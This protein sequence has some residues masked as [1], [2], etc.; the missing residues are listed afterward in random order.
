[1]G[2]SAKRLADVRHYALAAVAA[3]A[4]TF[5]RLRLDP[6]M[7]HSHNRHLFFLPTVMIVAWLWG[8]GPGLLA[9][10]MFAVA[11]RIF[12]TDATESFIH[13]NS[14]IALFVLVSVAICF[15]IRSL[16]RARQRADEVT[17]SREQLLAVVAHDLTNPLNAVKLAEERLRR[18]GP[19]GASVERGLDTIRNASNRMDRLLR[20]LVDTT[21]IDHDEL[22]VM[23]RP[24]PVAPLVREVAELYA[25]QAQAA[26]VTVETNLPAADA[27]VDGDRDRLM[28]V[29]GNLLANALKFT[30][31]GGRVALRA[32]ER[33]ETVVFEIEDTGAGIKPEHLPHIFERF[34]TYDTRGTGLGLFIAQSLVAAHGGALRVRSEPGKGATFWFEIPRRGR[35]AVSPSPPPA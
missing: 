22:V 32:A 25:P 10:A 13:A 17:R 24:E 20:D 27:L 28:Q 2:P 11:L 29:L 26:G 12:W 1:M 35:A 9:A 19:D 18:I 3:G 31:P 23:L 34:R 7:G 4:V 5:G 15:T 6:W 16:Q 21:R 30:P 8:F 33:A 14:D